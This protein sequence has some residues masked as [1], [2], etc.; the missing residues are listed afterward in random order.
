MID[1]L[2]AR[3]TSRQIAI[4]GGIVVAFLLFAAVAVSSIT[5]W[6]YS[7]DL[8]A[9][10][11]QEKAKQLQKAVSDAFR[12]QLPFGDKTD[13]ELRAITKQMQADN[14]AKEKALNEVEAAERTGD[15][16]KIADAV[17][18]MDAVVK[19]INDRRIA[20]K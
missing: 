14:D 3:F 2:A 8:A 5:A 11:E 10:R 4:V 12:K 16:Q 17:S 7:A 9:K 15:R 18:R 20:K 6:S 19:A 13:D 1:S